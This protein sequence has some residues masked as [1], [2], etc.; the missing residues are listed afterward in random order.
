[1]EMCQNKQVAVKSRHHAFRSEHDI[2]VTAGVE[3]EQT[4]KK[5][6]EKYLQEIFLKVT[7]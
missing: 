3:Y 7:D 1:M 5:L 2:P 6:E 4:N